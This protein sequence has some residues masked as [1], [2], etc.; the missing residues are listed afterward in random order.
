MSLTPKLEEL[1]D[2]L[3][4]NTHNIWAKERILQ[5]WTYG[6]NEDPDMHR[7]PHLVSYSNVDDAIKK[8]NRDTASETIRT[9]LVYGY[10]L[11]A[12]TG[13][14]AEGKNSSCQGHCGCKWAVVGAKIMKCACG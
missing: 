8:A 3:A 1:V 5:G 6:L 4:E 10:I 12:P 14:Q 13:D 2:Q 9:L 11:E 7:S